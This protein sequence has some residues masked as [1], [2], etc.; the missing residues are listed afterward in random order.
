[1]TTTVKEN[2]YMFVCFVALRPSQPILQCR[3]ITSI[4]CDFYPTLGCHDIRN[5]SKLQPKK[6]KKNE[7]LMLVN[8]NVL[9]G[10]QFYFY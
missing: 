4:L 6:K 7:Q 2:F 5:K 9:R 3:D 8:I 10:S 1:M